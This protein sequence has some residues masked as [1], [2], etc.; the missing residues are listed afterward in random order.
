LKAYYTGTQDTAK[1]EALFAAGEEFLKAQPGQQYVIGQMA[2]AGANGAAVGEFYKNLD[3]VKGYAEMGMKAFYSSNPPEG[4][5]PEEWNPLRDLVLAQMNQY[6]GWHLAIGTKGAPEQALDYLTKATQ[7]KGKEGVGWKDPNNYWLRST[8]YSNQYVELR[9][10]YD[11]L[12]NDDAKTGE[13]GKEIL[14]KVNQLL[15]PQLIPEYARVFATAANPEAKRF[16]DAPKHQL[17]PY[18][19]F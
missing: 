19:E 5:K 11:S 9:K 1:L 2:L 10:Q 14:K 6:I 16:Y 12:P 13:A 18:S 4:W 17:Q 8:I 15:D 7:V 3:K